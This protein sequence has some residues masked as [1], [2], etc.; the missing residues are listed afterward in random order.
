MS[1]AAVQRARRFNLD[2]TFDAFWQAHA[3]VV[4]TP[5][6]EDVQADAPAVPSR[7]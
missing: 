2:A 6:P 1:R 5:Q 7:L 4:A 3:D